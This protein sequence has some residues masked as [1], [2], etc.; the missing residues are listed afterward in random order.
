MIKVLG[1][2]TCF[3]RKEK[4][5]RA[6]NNLIKG[7]PEIEFHFIIADDASTDGEQ[8]VIKGWMRCECD[9]ERAET[10]DI[11]TSIV[12]IVPHK[13]NSSCTFAIISSYVSP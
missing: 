9:M 2:M 1:L 3:N 13:T 5:V 7:N 10:F 11:P 4:T 6:L 8:D 12:I